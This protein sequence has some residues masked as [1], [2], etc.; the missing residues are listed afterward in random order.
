MQAG[1]QVPVSSQVPSLTQEQWSDS[2]GPQPR[3][4]QPKTARST[5]NA[6]HASF[7]TALPGSDPPP[8]AL[9]WKDRGQTRPRSGPALRSVPNGQSRQHLNHAD[10]QAT[11]VPMIRG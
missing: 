8:L 4:P 5:L 7:D 2:Q 6:I 9:S 10:Q 1:S 3:Q 11:S